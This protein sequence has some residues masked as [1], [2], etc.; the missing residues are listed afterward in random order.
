MELQR[1]V[2]EPGLRLEQ[3]RVRS[4]T[5]D[6]G[7]AYWDAPASP[8]VLRQAA[9]YDNRTS[10]ALSVLM[11][12]GLAASIGFEYSYTGSSDTFRNESLRAILRAPF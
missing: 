10:A 5:A 7:L 9:E 6:Q 1:P 3:R 11:R 12:F 2:V 8:Y 4:G